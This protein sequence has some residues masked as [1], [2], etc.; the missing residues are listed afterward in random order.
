MSEAIG[1]V[2]L[3]LAAPVVKVEA[4]ALNAAHFVVADEDGALPVGG[5]RIEADGPDARRASWKA[6]PVVQAIVAAGVPA[7]LSFNAGTHL[8]NLTLFT[9][10]G[11]LA[12]AKASVPCGFLHLPYLPEQVAWL[13]TGPRSDGRRAPLASTDLPSMALDT[14]VT[15]VNAA[16]AELARQ[17][18]ALADTLDRTTTETAVHVA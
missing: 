6:D 16:V 10:L 7:S 15:A 2:T 8:C 1:L 3:A 14:Q 5:V 9:F 17:A 13:M 18:A 4:M 11:A 12:A